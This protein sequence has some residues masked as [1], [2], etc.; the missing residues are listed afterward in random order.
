MFILYYWYQLVIGNVN[1]DS[2]MLAYY[3]LTAISVILGLSLVLSAV[4]RKIWIKRAGIV[5]IVFSIMHI[6]AELFPQMMQNPVLQMVRTLGSFLASF[7]SILWI[8]NF[9]DEIKF[10]PRESNFLVDGP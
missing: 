2:Y 6:S 5:I 3:G 8:L 4:R 9:Q 1:L 10:L 7:G